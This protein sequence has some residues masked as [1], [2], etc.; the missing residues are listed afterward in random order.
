MAV[1]ARAPTERETSENWLPNLAQSSNTA[2]TGM[3]ILLQ[4]AMEN[5]EIYACHVPKNV[6]W[7]CD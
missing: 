4:A 2:A 3:K 7:F 1:L 6:W 5:T